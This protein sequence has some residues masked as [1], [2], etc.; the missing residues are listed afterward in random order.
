MKPF[1]QRSRRIHIVDHFCHKGASYCSPSFA[2]PPLIEAIVGDKLFDSNDFQ[3]GGKLLL[4][5]CK[6]IQDLFQIGEK[7]AL[8]I[9]PET[10]F[11][12]VRDAIVAKMTE[13]P[14]AHLPRLYE[15]Q[16][17]FCHFLETLHFFLFCLK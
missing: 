13:R 12:P 5:F 16:N 9:E 8:N 4:L 11:G 2:G 14:K 15:I 6:R 7:R 17:L 1:P 10:L 3:D